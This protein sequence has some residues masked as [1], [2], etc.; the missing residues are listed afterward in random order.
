MKIASALFVV[1]LNCLAATSAFAQF[2][3]A[4]KVSPSVTVIGNESDPRQ[5]LI[6]KA[7]A[8]WNRTLEEQGT[9]FRIGSILKLKDSVPDSEL[10]SL[11]NAVVGRTGIKVSVPEALTTHNGDILVYLGGTAFVSFVSPFSSNGKRVVGIRNIYGPP[12]NMPNVALNVITHELGHV[13]GI[14]HNAD[15]TTLMCGRPANC[16]P[17]AFYSTKEKFFPMSALEVTQ[18]QTMYPAAWKAQP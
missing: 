10:A 8:F 16:R 2:G 5:I 3:I 18:I 6:E 12:M 15:E 14:G 1:L 7:V 4:W 13:L 9:S 11:S 17:D